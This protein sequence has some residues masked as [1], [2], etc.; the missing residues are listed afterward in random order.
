MFFF[1]FAGGAVLKLEFD[2]EIKLGGLHLRLG[3][4]IGWIP[5]VDL[6]VEIHRTGIFEPGFQWFWFKFGVVLDVGIQNFKGEL[7]KKIHSLQGMTYPRMEQDCA[8]LASI[9]TKDTMA[10][11]TGLWVEESYGLFVK[12]LEGRM[13]RRVGL[14]MYKLTRFCP[15]PADKNKCLLRGGSKEPVSAAI[16]FAPSPAVR[17]KGEKKWPATAL[18]YRKD[19]KTSLKSTPAYRTDKRKN[20]ERTK[21][22][23]GRNQSSSSLPPQPTNIPMARPLSPPHEH[24]TLAPLRIQ[25]H[26]SSTKRK[27]KPRESHLSIHMAALVSRDTLPSPTQWVLARRGDGHARPSTPTAA[28]PRPKRVGDK[29]HRESK[30]KCGENAWPARA[31]LASQV[32]RIPLPKQKSKKKTRLKKRRLTLRIRTRTRTRPAPYTPKLDA[33]RGISCASGLPCPRSERCNVELELQEGRRENLPKRSDTNPAPAARAR[34]AAPLRAAA[35]VH[36]ELERGEDRCCE[37]GGAPAPGPAHE[38]QRGASGVGRSRRNVPE[39]PQIESALPPFRPFLPLTPTPL[40]RA[41]VSGAPLPRVQ[42]AN[43]RPLF[44]PT[45]FADLAVAVDFVGLT[46]GA[47]GL[48]MDCDPVG[49]R[50]AVVGGSSEEMLKHERYDGL[51]GFGGGSSSPSYPGDI[52]DAGGVKSFWLRFRPKKPSPPPPLFLPSF[53]SFCCPSLALVLLSSDSPAYANPRPFGLDGPAALKETYSAVGEDAWELAAYEEL[54]ALEP[55]A[56]A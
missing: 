27:V 41:R 5:R 33:A 1:F 21:K 28:P 14:A 49:E 20:G 35:Q 26:S 3:I 44:A 37:L 38:P 52:D 18:V 9:S 56:L 8:P 48:P 30:K 10:N 22:A 17:R 40:S 53:P 15:P 19:V 51:P 16:P 34:V 31:H 23:G 12:C 25:R 47:S 45:L 24:P 6:L 32:H 39:A 7:K 43:R 54:P 4:G 29:E 46:E 11:G 42:N 13:I 55:L 50:L 36:L 2:L